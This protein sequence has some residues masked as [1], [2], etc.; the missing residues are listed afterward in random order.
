MWCPLTPPCFCVLVVWR[1]LPLIVRARVCVGKAVTR[2]SSIEPWTWEGGS[3]LLACNL[4]IHKQRNKY[5]SLRGTGTARTATQHCCLGWTCAVVANQTFKNNLHSSKSRV[6]YDVCIIT[7]PVS[8]CVCLMTFRQVSIFSGTRRLVTQLIYLARLTC[9]CQFQ[10][11]H[12]SRIECQ[13]QSWTMPS[14][15][16]N[17]I[18]RF[19]SSIL[20]PQFGCLTF[21]ILQYTHTATH[22]DTRQFSNSET[23]VQAVSRII[24]LAMLRS[25][26][27]PYFGQYNREF[28]AKNI[29]LK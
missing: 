2:T 18:P 29:I 26:W 19:Q 4:A 15:Q 9:T 22:S 1:S 5:Q 23:F 17:V 11:Q 6:V 25:L 24:V 7:S 20:F 14:W 28:L 10:C 12:K 27:W 21:V 3:C 8:A 13:C 16:K